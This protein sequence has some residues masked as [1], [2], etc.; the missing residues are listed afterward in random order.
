MA[1]DSAGEPSLRS[2]S[3]SVC[4][5]SPS[6]AT[7]S[8]VCAR[9]SQAHCRLTPFAVAS[10]ANAACAGR[11]MQIWAA[12]R[13]TPPSEPRMTPGSALGL[14]MAAAIAARAASGAP[15][16]ATIHPGPPA[17]AAGAAAPGRRKPALPAEAGAYR[18]RQWER[19]RG[20]PGITCT[21]QVKGRAEIPF[22]RQ[23]IMDRAYLR[24]RS[25]VTDLKLLVMTVPAVIGGR[26]AY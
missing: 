15:G 1:D 4:P 18:N 22:Q 24:Q 2:A 16:L 19:L 12:A 3:V 7:T 10:L 5:A 11:R 6:S 21:W 14:P 26:G 25:F 13:A 8:N 23:A 20:K 9:F 17:A